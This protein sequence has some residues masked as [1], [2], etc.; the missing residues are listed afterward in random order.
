V[1]ACSFGFAPVVLMYASGLSSPAEIPLLLFFAACVVWRLAYF[2]TIG[3]QGDGKKRYFCGLPTTYVALVL[4]L[5]FLAGFLGKAW[6]RGSVCIAMAGLALA[7]VSTFPVRKPS[8]VCYLLFPVCGI[9][10]TAVFVTFAG[11]FM[12]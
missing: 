6:L 12:Q 9:A 3:L 8:G 4:P 2:D 7:M 10:L 5:A 1:D 11:Q